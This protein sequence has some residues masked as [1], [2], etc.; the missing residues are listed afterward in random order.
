MNSYLLNHVLKKNVI[1]HKGN[2]DSQSME[3]N[4]N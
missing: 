2:D 1:S 3:N 4:F